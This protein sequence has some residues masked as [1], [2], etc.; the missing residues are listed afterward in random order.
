MSKDGLTLL[1]M[2]HGATVTEAPWRFVGSRDIG[3]SEAGREQ[4][5]SWSTVL[6]GLDL[7]AAW[8]SDLSRARETAR[9]ALEA[10]RIEATELPGLRE[11]TLG[12]WEGLQVEEV[13]ERFPGAHEARGAD[14]ANYRPHGGESFADVAARALETLAFIRESALRQG[15][16]RVL[17]VAHAG[18]NRALVCALLGVSLSK[19]FSLG[20]DHACL[21]VIRLEPGP[22]VLKALNL[23]PGTLP[24]PLSG[25]K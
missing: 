11:L 6:A 12:Q 25:R 17:A 23:P 9:L 24:W 10:S 21:N 16:G 2:R 5:R 1:L 15:A 20:Q 18:F 19:V 7:D 3:L 4:A 14:L 8:C 22:P 13:R